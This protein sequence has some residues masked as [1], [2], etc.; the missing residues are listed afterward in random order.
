MRGTDLIGLENPIL[1]PR[2]QIRP[3][4]GTLALFTEGNA[5]KPIAAVNVGADV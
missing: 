2:T 1:D 5:G 4:V 3:A